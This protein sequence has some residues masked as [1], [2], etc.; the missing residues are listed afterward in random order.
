MSQVN[1]GREVI[2]GFNAGHGTVGTTP[3]P[4]QTASWTVNKHVVVRADSGNGNTVTV[5]P[6][7]GGASGG[8]VLAAGQQTPPIYVDDVNKVFVVGG[9]SGQVYSWISN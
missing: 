7:A 8:F 3:V 9:A 1:I 4:L 5:G 2:D 6:T